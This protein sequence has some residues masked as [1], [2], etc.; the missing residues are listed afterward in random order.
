VRGN[1]YEVKDDKYIGQ[2]TEDRSQ[3]TEEK[4]NDEK[5]RS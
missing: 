2:K 5:L 1:R 4:R 3:R